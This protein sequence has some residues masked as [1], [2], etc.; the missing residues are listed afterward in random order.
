MQYGMEKTDIKLK[1]DWQDTQVELL[2]SLHGFKV[3]EVNDKIGSVD[4]V[5][6]TDDEKKKL[7]RVVVDPGLNASKAYFKTVSK[8]LEAVE[9]GNY[10]EA[11]ILAERF[12]RASKR[13]A[14]K[15]ENLEYIS[16]DNEHH[17]LFE[18]IEA[19][20]DQTRELCEA[21]CGKFPT[22]V[23]DCRGYQDGEYTCP[24]RRLSDDADFHAERGWIDLLMSDFSKLV[25]LQ[26][27]MN[28]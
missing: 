20:Q 9:D 15:E 3:A 24:V 14:R 17:S 23:E 5:A 12:T 10:D 4:Y 28:N 7:L 27:K 22:R 2:K 26:R 8:T 16:P 11:T 13:L 25:M 1:S 21:K 18:L 6:E 19:V